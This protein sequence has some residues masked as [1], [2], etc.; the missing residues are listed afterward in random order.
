MQETHLKKCTKIDF[1][2]TF[3]S[4]NVGD[5][6][7]FWFEDTKTHATT[8]RTLYCKFRKEKKLDFGLK[9]SEVNNPAGTIVSRIS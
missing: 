8:W 1:L 6:E 4:F 9:I 2:N 7:T 5:T 3:R